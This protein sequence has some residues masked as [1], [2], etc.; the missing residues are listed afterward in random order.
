MLSDFFFRVFEHLLPFGSRIWQM[1]LAS[2]LRDFFMGLTSLPL[3]VRDFIDRLWLDTRPQ[4]TLQLPKWETQFGLRNASLTDQQKRDR[5]DAAWKLTGGQA[6]RYLQDTMQA[7]GFDVFI[8]E[9]WETPAADPPVARNPNVHLNDGGPSWLMAAGEPIAEC[10][11]AL[12]QA[13]ET[14]TP[15]GFL[16]V[17][18][19]PIA[20]IV[21]L[22]AGDPEMQSG[23]A[24]AQSGEVQSIT[25][26]LFP[27]TIPTDSDEWAQFLYWGA[28]TF[29]TLAT[30]QAAR[31]DE[32][33]D[34]L[35]RI[36]PGE[37]WLGLLITYA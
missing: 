10:G 32:F 28:A 33:E 2:P 22:G 36:C 5:L 15:Q 35:L 23:E 18:K 6:P 1:K 31:K 16:L 34:L 7:H 13:G 8:H 37:K 9:W 14:T 26:S 4:D 25:F 24:L 17:N 3:A 12:A 21:F 27:Y 20:T 29:P 11:E 19:I 30:V